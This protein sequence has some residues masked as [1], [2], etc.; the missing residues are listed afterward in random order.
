MWNLLFRVM[1]MAFIACLVHA[2]SATAQSNIQFRVH[3]PTLPSYIADASQIS[4]LDSAMIAGSPLLAGWTRRADRPGVKGFSAYIYEHSGFINPQNT[5]LGTYPSSNF[6]DGYELLGPPEE[7]DK[8]WDDNTVHETYDQLAFYGIN[9]NGVTCGVLWSDNATP[10]SIPVYVDLNPFAGALELKRIPLPDGA[11]G[12]R[13]WA[14]NE[15]DEIAVRLYGS[16]GA[17]LGPYI[18]KPSI[19]GNKEERTEIPALAGL[20][21]IGRRG[22]FNTL[23]QFF[24]L[25]NDSP[26]RYTLGNATLVEESIEFKRFRVDSVT[27]ESF[28]E[29][30]SIIGCGSGEMFAGHLRISKGKN[31]GEYGVRYSGLP[32]LE[33]RRWSVETGWALNVGVVRSVNSSGDVVGNRRDSNGDYTY[34]YHE[35]GPGEDDDEYFPNVMDLVDPTSDPDFAFRLGEGSN[36]RVSGDIQT[37]S[38]SSGFGWMCGKRNVGVDGVR[39]YLLQPVIPGSTP[40]ISVSPVTGLVT[41]ESGSSDSFEVVLDAAPSADVTIGISTSNTAEGLMVDPDNLSGPLLDSYDLVFDATNWDQAQTVT[42]V[43]QGDGVADG[44]DV[45]YTIITDPAVSG[46]GDYNGLDAEDVQVINL[47][48]SSSATY[49]TLDGPDPDPP[50]AI[51]DNN[52][53]GISSTVLVGDHNITGLTVSL[54]IDHPRPS[55]LAVYLFDPDNDPNDPQSSSV[56]LEVVSGDNPIDLN[57]I[58]VT[59][60]LG[61]WTILV[62]DDRKKKTGTLLDWSITV[63]Y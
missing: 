59:N 56:L 2:P 24:G 23:R 22:E 63:D 39:L 52:P 55:D 47:D 37:D 11:V 35:A 3:L 10:N 26:T 8:N 14:V 12:G 42:V 44:N 41:T 38:D 7:W 58:D 21:F 51:P 1:P 54:N 25:A 27:V 53:A 9:S 36:Q 17:D 15:N 34:Y 29:L 61:F 28:S 19:G 40:G 60:S 43:G 49:S 30:V 4:L 48:P 46:D 18:Y 45:A 31:K 33:E 20:T 57:E 32:A 13:A 16:D 62:V 5:Y 50:I 6:W